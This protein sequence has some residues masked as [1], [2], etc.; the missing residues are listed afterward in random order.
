MPRVTAI[1]FCVINALQAVIILA[2]N[3]FTIYVFWTRRLSLKR[4]AFLLI[5]LAVTDFLIGAATLVEIIYQVSQKEDIEAVDYEDPISAFQLA[6]TCSSVFCLVGISLERV[7][8][9]LWPLRHRVASTNLYILSIALAWIAGVTI[10]V[11]YTLIT[12]ELVPYIYSTVTE[13]A[14]LFSLVIFVASYVAIRTRMKQ[15]VCSL[16]VHNRL[17]VEQNVKLS[18]T[19]FIVITLSLLLW[20]PVIILVIIKVSCKHCAVQGLPLSITRVLHLSNSIVNPIVY[21][22]RMPMFKEAME[23]SLDRC[24]CFKWHKNE[25]SVQSGQPGYFD[26]PL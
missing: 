21:S 6:C 23:R 13:I 16:E 14:L 24:R 17:A 20:L 1:V 22:Y 2:G 7:Y 5:N 10:A 26:I 18:R 19:L 3:A 12:L 11:I 25:N 8:A 4:T 15:T 9:I